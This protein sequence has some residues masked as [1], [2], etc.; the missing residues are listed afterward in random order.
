M[1]KGSTLRSYNI[2]YGLVG[3]INS[4][5]NGMMKKAANAN[6]I[7]IR[8]S[9]FYAGH[10]SQAL[11]ATKNEGRRPAENRWLLS[12]SLHGGPLT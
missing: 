3:A 5:T 7:T 1:Y 2:V 11:V 9:G 8:M 4:Q 10:V 12:R 6:R